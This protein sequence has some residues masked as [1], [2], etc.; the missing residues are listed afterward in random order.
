LALHTQQLLRDVADDTRED[1]LKFLVQAQNAMQLS[2][3]LFASGLLS[4]DRRERIEQY[5]FD[6]LALVPQTDGLYFADPSGQFLFTKRSPNDSVSRYETKLIDFAD[7]VR[8]VRKIWRDD[9]F[10]KIKRDVLHDDTYD[11]RVRPWYLKA[12][13]IAQ[14]IWSDPYIFSLLRR[15]V[16]PSPCVCWTAPEN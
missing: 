13:K 12:H 16:S 6:R 10:K 7:G 8:R 9:Q 11:P 1:A 5:F 15:W 4:F 14:L 2:E 3:K